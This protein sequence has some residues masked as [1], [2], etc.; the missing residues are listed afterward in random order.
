MPKETF[1]YQAL[2]RADGY[3]NPLVWGFFYRGPR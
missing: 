3:I 1:E 2:F